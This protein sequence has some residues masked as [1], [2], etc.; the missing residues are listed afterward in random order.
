VNVNIKTRSNTLDKWQKWFWFTSYCNKFIL[1]R[2]YKVRQSY[3]IPDFCGKAQLFTDAPQLQALF[4]G[5]AVSGS[6][7]MQQHHKK[8][9]NDLSQ[10]CKGKP[11]ISLRK[12]RE[13]E[14]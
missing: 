11:Y 1:T 2:W 14:A 9:I 10:R 12:C 6:T 4:C 13:Q 7:V 5:A 8:N 3:K